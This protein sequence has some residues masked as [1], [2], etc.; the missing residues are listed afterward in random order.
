M[1]TTKTILWDDEYLKIFASEALLSG[2]K[3]QFWDYDPKTQEVKD[4]KNKHIRKML[5]R[6]YPA[7][8]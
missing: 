6:F 5:M 3:S 4:F 2:S 1:E 8:G 7:L